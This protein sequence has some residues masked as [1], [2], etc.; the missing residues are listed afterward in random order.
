MRLDKQASSSVTQAGGGHAVASLHEGLVN[1]HFYDVWAYSYPAMPGGVHLIAKDAKN[2]HP[3]VYVQLDHIA[4]WWTP[5]AG[6][7]SFLPYI[8][9]FINE[10]NTFIRPVKLPHFSLVR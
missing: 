5:E 2:N 9:P 6:D 8:L 10:D 3:D 4:S 1:K 7:I